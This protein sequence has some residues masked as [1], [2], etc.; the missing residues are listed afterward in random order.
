MRRAYTSTVVIIQVDD[1]H[2]S[3]PGKRGCYITSSASQPEVVALMLAALDA[4][5]GM[6][7]LEIG[8]GTGTTPPCS[9]TASARRTSPV[10][11]STSDL[12][13]HARRAL[14]A[15]DYPVT[16]ITDDGALGYPPGTPYD[17]A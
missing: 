4:E 6:R 13:E 7:V 1:G 17:R 14:T 11:R 2:P 10:W 9:P 5:P 15:T 16:V 12:A 3:G 8:T